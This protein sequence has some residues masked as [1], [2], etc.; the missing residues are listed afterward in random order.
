MHRDR[1]LPLVAALAGGAAFG[2]ALALAGVAVARANHGAAAAPPPKPQGGWG[3]YREDDAAAALMGRPATAS[4]SQQ[5]SGTPEPR[6]Q[7]NGDNGS[8]AGPASQQ[9]Q[10]DLATP[11][12]PRARPRGGGEDDAANGGQFDQSRPN[13]NGGIGAAGMGP[14]CFSLVSPIDAKKR[15]DPYDARPREK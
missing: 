10:Q 15:S 11:Q 9:Q 12:R 4:S 6:E 3:A 14:S 8:D 1:E 13:E 5:R 7:L 2:A